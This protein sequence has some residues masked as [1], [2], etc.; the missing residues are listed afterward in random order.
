M[1]KN[2]RNNIYLIAGI[3]P[4]FLERGALW[5]SEN[6]E[7][8]LRAVKTQNWWEEH[9][10]L[11]EEG[12]T[13]KLSEL[14]RRL[15]EL[16]YQKTR[17]IVSPGEFSQL[18]DT[19][20]IS[21]VNRED[22]LR[23]EFRG[24]AIERIISEKFGLKVEKKIEKRQVSFRPGEY[25]VHIDHGIGIYQGFAAKGNETNNTAESNVRGPIS[26]HPLLTYYSKLKAGVISKGDI[27]R[28]DGGS[29]NGYHIV[30]Y[31]APRKGAEPDR[32]LVPKNQE[33]RLSLY[34]GFDH[35]TIH[36][37]GGQLWPATKRK[38]KESAEAFARALLEIYAKRETAT[39]H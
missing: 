4:S 25:V 14:L 29:E 10:A 21:A 20:R 23:L 2:R 12:A 13:K 16:G 15:G 35:P 36:R 5:F 18:G 8:I 31:A 17:N 22:I 32:L 30:E 1:D 24:N 34:I 38:V 27:R 3:T 11:L 33:K 28:E 37:L 9:V 6:E 7:K 19:L 39:R 26:D